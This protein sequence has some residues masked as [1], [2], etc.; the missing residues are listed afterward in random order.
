MLRPVVRLALGLALFVVGHDVVLCQLNGHDFRGDW[1]MQAATQPP[2]GWSVSVVYLN[3]HTDTVRDRNGDRIPS[4]GSKT[5]RGLSPS[6]WW[7]SQKKI[8]GGNYS[9]SVAP[10]IVNDTLEAPVL[11]LDDETTLGLGDLYVQPLNLGWHTPRFDLMAGLG[12]FIPTGRY[13]AGSDGNTGLGMWSFE[14]FGGATAYFDKRQ[15]WHVSALAFW[16]THTEKEETQF[17]VGDMLTVEGGLGKWLA[18][19]AVNLGVSYFAQWKLTDDDFRGVIPTGALDRHRLFGAGP[20]ITVVILDTDEAEGV[21]NA[22]Y[23]REFWAESNTQG[24]AFILAFTIE[25]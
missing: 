20:E 3:Y 25:F 11:G 4:L 5:I 22:R 14:V 12:V 17:R 23:L 15:T 13:E 10:V 19:G 18:K 6:V 8:F 1:G 16:Q 9:V 2:P 24:D 21:L 7:V